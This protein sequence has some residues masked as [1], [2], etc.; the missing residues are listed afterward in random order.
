LGMLLSGGKRAAL[1]G[2]IEF[3]GKGTEIY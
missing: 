3:F 2:F 1:Q